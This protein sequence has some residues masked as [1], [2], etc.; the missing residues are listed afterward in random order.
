MG[1]CS[2]SKHASAA[3][4]ERHASVTGSAVVES[5]IMTFVAEMTKS[6]LLSMVGGGGG[7]KLL[8]DPDPW[9]S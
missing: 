2:P 7:C 6:Q 8:S 4:W 5:V 1:P 3:V 9:Q